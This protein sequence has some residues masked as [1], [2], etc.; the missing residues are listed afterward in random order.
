M[1]EYCGSGG[2]SHAPSWK[3]ILPRASHPSGRCDV[4][5]SLER[6][7]GNCARAIAA[8]QNVAKSGCETARGGSSGYNSYDVPEFIALPIAKAL[9]IYGGLEECLGKVFA[10]AEIDR[11]F[12]PL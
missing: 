7:S 1:L 11:I 4:H 6:E 3:S 2:V 12:C 5:I 8:D 9:R 10:G